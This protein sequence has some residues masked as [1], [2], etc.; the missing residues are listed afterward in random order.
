MLCEGR[1]HT[2]DPA[3]VE[4]FVAEV[5]RALASLGDEHVKVA[6]VRVEADAK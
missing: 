4:A 1:V 5:E 6:L 3:T 2:R